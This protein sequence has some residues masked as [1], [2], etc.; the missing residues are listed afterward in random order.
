MVSASGARR[1]GRLGVGIIGAGK[2][3][4]V[5][6]AALRA[7]DHAV[8]GVSAVSEASRERAEMLLPGVP[9][10]EIPDIIE[11]SELVLIAVPDDALSELVDG[12]A[13]LGSWQPGQ[14]IAHTSGRFGISVLEPARQM[15]AIPLALH[16]A[17]TFTGM[18]LDLA[19]LPDCSFGI[20][21]PSAV[22]PVAQALV[23]E[24][25]AEPVVI[26]E[27][28]RPLYH[29]ALA[30]ASNHLVTITAQSTQLLTDIGVEQPHRMLGPLMRASL[31]NALSAGEGALT[32]PVARGDTGT[33]EA[34]I[35]ALNSQSSEDI[36]AAYRGLAIAT[37]QRAV[38]RG[39]LSRAQGAAITRALTI[40]EADPS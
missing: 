8:I 11:R 2:V 40:D 15:G 27:S 6:G 7:A 10:L 23:V 19:R 9:V 12:L 3:G 37:A 32:G 35:E 14:L 34:H 18:S 25:G 22:L 16:P 1:P 31:E 36:S 38:D 24:M 29:A 4:A 13:K 39:L 30:H 33:V 21:A 17:M 20:T 28:Q 5:L 26:D